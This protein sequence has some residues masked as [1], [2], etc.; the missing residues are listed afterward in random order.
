MEIFHW[1]NDW[2]GRNDTADILLTTW[3]VFGLPTVAT[4]SVG[5]LLLL[6]DAKN[7]GCRWWLVAAWL[8]SVGLVIV[9]MWSVDALAWEWLKT[10]VL[11][12]R[13]YI[14]RSV[15]LLLTEQTNNS[16]PSGETALCF[17]CAVTVLPLARG[18]GIGLLVLSALFGLARV[19]CGVNYL[20][21]VVAGVVLGASVSLVCCA[22]CGATL[23]TLSRWRQALL[24]VLPLVIVAVAAVAYI[25]TVSP[26]ATADASD[27]TPKPPAT[28]KVSVRPRIRE[29]LLGGH[30]ELAERRLL[31][32]LRISGNQ[33]RVAHVGVARNEF[34][35]VAEV[36]FDARWNGALTR[37]AVERTAAK[38]IRTAFQREPHLREIDVVGIVPLKTD[39]LFVVFSVNAR[40]TLLTPLR[41]PITDADF[42]RCFGQVYY[43]ER[44]LPERG[45]WQPPAA[46]VMFPLP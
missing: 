23:G 9:A 20:I 2:A 1:L 41:T 13:P 22:L 21:D 12:P 8:L 14:A 17:A 43:D 37:R 35:R 15:N 46:E 18:M 7:S 19:F 33:Q 29:R 25:A 10:P 44:R 28:G 24:G 39:R 5:A 45:S 16:F 36:W 31:N 30:L 3:A 38:I 6:P 42:L 34:Y 26:Y 11:R 40:R 4:L 32:W 27:K